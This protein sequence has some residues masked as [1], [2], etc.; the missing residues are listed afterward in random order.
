MGGAV[1]MLDGRG[2][3]QGGGRGVRATAGVPGGRGKDADHDLWSVED[4]S[5]REWMARL[6][7]ARLVKHLSTAEAVRAASLGVLRERRAK[8]ESTHPFYWGVFVA[9]GDWR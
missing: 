3:S 9:A 1:G 2:R 7:E 6:Y 4:Q 5:A 8:G